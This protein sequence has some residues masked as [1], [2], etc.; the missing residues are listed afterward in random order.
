[1]YK[2][3]GWQGY[4][5]WLGTGNVHKGAKR[6]HFLPFLEAV[7]YA[8]SLNLKGLRD[9]KKWCTNSG[10]RPAN[11]PSNP[12][13]A[14][15]YKGW[16]GYGHWLGSGNVHGGGKRSADGG[17]SYNEDHVAESCQVAT[18]TAGV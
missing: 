7:A 14:Y 12:D 17:W 11:I 6:S 2:D 9:W 16:Q 4:D 13:K 15:K 8:Q 1:M 10:S 5:H 18:P 3:E